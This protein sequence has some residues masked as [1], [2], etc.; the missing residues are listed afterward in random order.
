MAVLMLALTGSAQAASLS[1]DLPDYTPGSMVTIYGSGF[2][3]NETVTVQVVHADGDPANGD[4][5]DPW[6]VTA[7]SGG[8]F[9]AYWVVPFD[10]NLGETLLVTAEG[11]TSGL[12]ASVTF[13]DNIGTNL[14]QLQNGTNGT[15]PE[16]ANGNINGSNSCYSEG[17]V[18]PYRYFLTGVPN[19]ASHTFTISFEATKGGIHALDYL[20]Q[21]DLTES[22][23]IDSIGGA[24]SNTSTSAEP[25]CTNPAVVSVATLPHPTDPLNYASGDPPANVDDILSTMSPTFLIDGPGDFYGYNATGV[26]FSTYYYTGTVSDRE[27]NIDVTFTAIVDGDVGFFWGGHLARG[28]TDGWGFANGAAS[29]GGAPYHMRAGNV[30]GGGGAY[31]DRS[32]QN[33]VICLAPDATI[34][35]AATSEHCEGGTYSC[36]ISSAAGTFV[37]SATGATITS[38]Q[39]TTDITYTITA[40]LGETVTI[41]VE[42]CDDNGGCPGD[43][44]CNYDSIEFIVDQ[45]CEFSITCPADITI[46]CDA[47]TDPSNTGQATYTSTGTGCPSVSLEYSDSEVAGAC[48]QEKVITRTWQLVDG[49]STVLAECDQI[50]TVDDSVAP[51]CTVPADATIFQCV[52]TQVCLPVGCTDNCDPNPTISILSGPGAI[53]NGEWCYTPSTNETASVTVKCL[54]ACGNSCESTFNITFELNNSPVCQAPSDQTIFQ[55]EPTEVCLPVGCTDTDGNLL[56]SQPTIISG[57]GAIVNGEWCYTP[58][59]DE[60][61]NVTIQCE[62][63]CGATSQCSF[64]ITFEINEAP[65]CNVPGDATIFQ[66]VPTE[67]SVAVSCSDADGNLSPGYPQIV[68]GPGA[69]V[70]GEWVY[71]PTGSGPVTVTIRCQD[72]CGASCESSFT[73]TFEINEAPVCTVP[74]AQ[75]FFECDPAEPTQVC[76]PV[77]CTD[78]NGNLLAN[79][80][81]IVSG[82]GA[83]I[84][85]EWCYTPS[86]NETVDVTVQCEDECGAISTY[87]FTITF[88]VNE[89]PACQP[90]EVLSFHLSELTEICLPVSCADPNNNLLPDQPQLVSGP[91]T[92]ADGMWCYT[93]VR[94]YDTVVV[95]MSCEDEC[96][97]ICI[98]PFVVI[99]E[100]NEPPECQVPNDTIIMQCAPAQVCL[101]VGCTDPNDN[102]LDGQPTIISGPGVIANGEWCYTPAGDE[103][104]VVT[105]GCEDEDGATSQCTFAITFQ[106]NEAPVCTVPENQTFNQ[107]EPTE[108]CL[109]VGCS[110]ADGNLLGSQPTIVSGPGTIVNGE[111]CYTPS[112]PE[113]ATVT[114][115]CEDECGATCQS[116]FEIIFE[117]NSAPVCTVPDNQTFSQ[118]VATQVCLPIGCT[119]VDG[120]LVSTQ[121]TIISGPG[122]IVNSLWCYTPTGDEI[123]TVTVQCVDEC[124][125]TCQSTFIIT[126]EVNTAPVC[127]VPDDQTI[128]QCAP[129]QVCLPVGCTD[130]DDNLA[131]GTPTVKYGPGTIVNGEW[132]YTPQGTE[133]AVVTIECADECGATSECTFSIE[134][135]VNS[136][137]TIVDCP[138]DINV[139]WGTFISETINATDVD[140]TITFSLGDGS[141]GSSSITAAG[142]FTWNTSGSSV[143]GGEVTVIATDDCDIADTCTFNICV[144]N[145]PPTLTCSDPAQVCWGSTL[146]GQVIGDDPDGGPMNLFY[147]VLSFD[148]P[149][150]V[151]IDVATGEYSWE[152]SQSSEFAGTFELC[153]EVT[154]NANLCEPCSPANAD[155]CCVLLTVVPAY[156]VHIE[157]THGTL[158]GHY[159]DVAVY[160][161]SSVTYL[162]MGGFDFLIAYDASALTFAGATQG[163][164]LTDCEWEYFTYRYGASG[165]C[166]SG[167]PSGEIRLVG[168]AETNN[169][170]N[171]PICRTNDGVSS[172]LA[173]LTFLLSNDRTLEC[174]Y[175]PIRFHWYECS[176][177]TISSPGGDTLYLS[178][179]VWDYRPLEGQGEY[180]D[181]TNTTAPFPS[182]TGAHFSCDDG[183]DE[184][185]KTEPLRCLEFFNGGVDIICADSIDARG[186][187]NLDGLAY[188]ISDAVMYINYF[189]EG[190]SAFTD[191]ADTNAYGFAPGYEG[192]V[193][194]SDVNADGLTLTVSDMVYLIRVIVGDA[195]PYPKVIP[196]E[197]NMTN[198]NGILSVDYEMGAAYILVRGLETPTLLADN[199]DMKY[200]H[201]NGNTRIIIFSLSSESFMGEF[202][203]L[204]G[205]LIGLELATYEGQPAVTK[206]IPSEFKLDQNYPNPF[207]PSTV[208][209]FQLPSATQTKLEIYNVQG[210]KVATLVD[211]YLEAGTHQLRWE[212]IGASSGIYFY[213]LETE[214]ITETRKMILLK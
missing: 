176:D 49:S 88:E 118:C 103:T 149:G 94:E 17:D 199:L 136:A 18:V 208:I 7:S 29:V 12:L 14:D 35:C 137:P 20:A 162:E 62:D 202:V 156:Q 69:I 71:T 209:S 151:V 59:G 143:C 34:T 40:G 4:G 73:K 192:S 65:V 130:A 116:S 173:N 168:I 113:T 128:V 42:A 39:G 86:G 148:G 78:P 11:L 25:G 111:W 36:S 102:L 57:P 91:G 82:P 23:E 104:A 89:P 132:C 54:D 105:I 101:P 181:I 187:I 144:Y 81:T 100:V 41:S 160:L 67:Y 50:I 13:T 124:G 24:C 1:T 63:A 214:T 150:T 60:T 166:G 155:T 167:C 123:A 210:Q 194:A 28:I 44:C 140:G 112:G 97:E 122:T 26:S 68:S 10:D 45:C 177:N 79:Q 185:A 33:G 190:L 142:V 180:Q 189:I 186:D 32:I 135:V 6:N 2:Q 170:D 92:I 52:P 164:F 114:V 51:V 139:H 134:F 172:V 43:F 197:V 188:T 119:D 133:T 21:Y 3:A 37:W 145:D 191:V 178:S 175:V 58:A 107:C 200:S 196:L 195:L 55:C 99:I 64:A 182:Y 127:T 53:V 131:A 22:A 157:K 158:Q 8:D 159:V 211:G 31:Q 203:A 212:S 48:A 90:P 38:G 56:A 205:D 198:E 152:T 193:A 125:A 138:G 61:A 213:R 179:A 207:N 161:D 93:P 129:E 74:E 96:G 16:W 5:H 141:P 206:L 85:G 19:T 117:V 110:D 147:S 15:T 72:D 47:S 109:P 146:T 77:E 120:N 171:H 95:H 87:S 108:V 84:N 184:A 126:F 169:G 66:C 75:G 201:E 30:D 70:G 106:A 165:N 80:P 183:S 153:I 154:D 98:D 83:I 174:N 27:L 115:Q 204:S 9:V 46:E 76:L 121:P 163:Q